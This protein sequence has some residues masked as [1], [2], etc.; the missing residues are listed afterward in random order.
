M[1]G[2]RVAFFAEEHDLRQLITAFEA[3]TRCQYYEAGSFESN[4]IPTYESLLEV[5]QLGKV[6]Y[7]DWNHAT[8]IL[9]LPVGISLVVRPVAQRAGG[10]RYFIDQLENPY[11]F[12]L[13]LGGTFQ[14]GV[15]VAS[16]ASTLATDAASLNIFGS[17]AKL[18]KKQA[19]IG[20][21]YVGKHANM[22]LQEDWRLVTSASSPGE[23][24][25]SKQ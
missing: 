4:V 14:P 24:D 2:K 23:Y 3:T 5:S 21:F 16:G 20:T 10:V 9:V 22:Y 11:G 8:R 13:T 19:R 15:L 12:L 6:Q 7:G 17:L 1:R 18:V 25:L